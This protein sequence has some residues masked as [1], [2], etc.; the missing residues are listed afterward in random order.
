MLYQRIIQPTG[1]CPVELLRFPPPTYSLN[2]GFQSCTLAST[3]LYPRKFHSNGLL[4]PLSQLALAGLL[5]VQSLQ[6]LLQE[7]GFD[8]AVCL[9][10][11]TA[12]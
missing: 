7:S 9:K 4:V 3:R 2:V 8:L 12:W 5:V 1:R 10:I 11:Q 6:N